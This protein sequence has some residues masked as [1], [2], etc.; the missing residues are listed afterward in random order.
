MY[1]S[2]SIQS[3]VRFIKFNDG[4]AS[5]EQLS[6]LVQGKFHLIRDR[7]VFYC[8]D[9]AVRFCSS[10]NKNF[11]NT[12]LSLSTLQ[13]YDS[14]P[15]IVVFV[16]PKKNFMMLANTTFL[17]KISHSSQE[18]RIDNIKGSF[19]GSDIYREFNER[20]NEPDNF[21][22]LFTTHENYSFEENLERLV[23]STNYIHPTGSKFCP[24]K[25][26][27]QNILES[28]SRAE[29]FLKSKEYKELNDDLSSRVAKVSSE[30]AIASFIDNV[31]LRGRII[32]YLITAEGD[33]KAALIESLRTGNPL[34]ELFTADKLGDYE[35]EFEE[36]ITATDIK[37]KILFLLSNPKGYNID[38]LLSFLSN[39]RSVYMIYVVA[40][41]KNKDISTRLCSMYNRQLLSGTRVIKHWAGRNS[42]GVTQYDGR[43]L[44]DIVSNFDSTID[45]EQSERYIR[46]LLDR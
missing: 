40:I 13:K 17:K 37:T 16:T 8:K 38:K 43:S 32:E 14:R 36:Y 20:L 44:E 15:F 19:N 45:S 46:E 11:S 18:L 31:N 21:N 41:N 2:N 4:I 26:E 27:E 1:N 42:R 6:S 28:I 24:T 5:K 25:I 29:S 9:Y 7:S 12:V 30:I 23:N 22:Y 3:L 39:E 34:P 35:R 33:L 10:K